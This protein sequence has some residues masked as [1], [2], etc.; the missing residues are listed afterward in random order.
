[1]CIFAERDA[2]REFGHRNARHYGVRTS[3]SALRVRRPSA[4]VVETDITDS[5]KNYRWWLGSQ[6]QGETKREISVAGQATV[7]NKLASSLCDHPRRATTTRSSGVAHDKRHPN[8]GRLAWFFSLKDTAKELKSAVARGTAVPTSF[9]SR[10]YHRPSP[11][12]VAGTLK[13]R[14]GKCRA[15]NRKA[16]HRRRLWG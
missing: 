16:S 11:V 3:N 14:G 2:R 7:H 6:Q 12:C 8:M 10:N 1:M 9:L 15:V 13:R 5:L 4:L